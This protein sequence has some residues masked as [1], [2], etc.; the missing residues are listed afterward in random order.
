LPKRLFVALAFLLCFN[1][2]H[3]IYSP[4][5][6]AIV[7][8]AKNGEIIYSYNADQRTQPASLVKMMTLLLTFKALQQRKIYPT[9]M[10]RVS[11]HAA[12]QKPTVLG[13]KAGEY[14]SVRNA[15]LALIVKSAN[16]IATA[17]AEHLGGNSEKRF[18]DMMNKE[19]QRLGM[20]S[21]IFFNP[22]GWKDPRQLTTARD[23]AK[24]ARALLI[25]YPSYYH[26]FAHK[27]FC[28][29]NKCIKGH[30][31]L[32]GKKGDIIVDGIKTGFLNASG[33]N[34]AASAIKGKTR[35]IAVVLGGRTSRKRDALADLLLKKG[36]SKLISRE[37]PR[38]PSQKTSSGSS[39][40]VQAVSGVYNKL[41]ELSHNNGAN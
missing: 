1:L 41:K 17:L 25:E 22:S 7:I 10:I 3:A 24:L 37:I 38:R 29:N 39:S 23:M 20:S 6:A 8:N 32:L 16:D 26:L 12:A 11:P 30:Y 21:T 13:L 5:N 34:L 35:L 9:T 2:S 4:V 31:S 18:I 14:I 33:F 19:A 27:K 36:F 15:I 40:S 28:L